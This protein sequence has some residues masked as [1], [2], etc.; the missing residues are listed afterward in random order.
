MPVGDGLAIVPLG[1]LDDFLDANIL[2]RLAPEVARRQ[3]EDLVAAVVKPFQWKPEFPADGPPSSFDWSRVGSFSEDAKILIELLALFPCGAPWSISLPFL[4][5][6]IAGRAFSLAVRRSI[7]TT[8]G[9]SRRGGPVWWGVRSRPGAKRSVRP[10]GYSPA[11]MGS[12]T[13]TVR[14]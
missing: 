7:E 4:G 2:D 9:V 8:V 6:F 14:R 10:R 11:E 13:G 12:G 1:W 3:P 5:G